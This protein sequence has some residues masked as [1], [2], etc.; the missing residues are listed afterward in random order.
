MSTMAAVNGSTQDGGEGERGECNVSAVP[1]PPLQSPRE[2]E[3]GVASR[4]RLQP[5]L[6]QVARE[7]VGEQGVE[8]GEQRLR[9]RRPALL[10]PA[11]GEG[12]W[13]GSRLG[14]GSGLGS[15][16]GCSVRVRVSSPRA[17]RSGAGTGGAP[18]LVRVRVRVRVR[19]EE[20]G[21]GL[22]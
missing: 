18:H 17:C 2:A 4:A 6:A 14:W 12:H 7:E 10:Q 22:V 9:P 13:S 11:R 15:G 3:R 1:P 21:E 19:G 5:L 20:S 8:R 16:S